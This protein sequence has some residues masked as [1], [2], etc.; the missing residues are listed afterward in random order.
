MS[1]ECV[2]AIDDI[3]KEINKKIKKLEKEKDNLEN[4]RKDFK[5][6]VCV[7]YKDSELYTY[8]DIQELYAYGI[9]TENKFE[10]LVN[11][12]ENL[13]ATS[14]TDFQIEVLEYK[15]YYYNYFKK[16]LLNTKEMEL[17][18]EKRGNS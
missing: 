12:L 2:T 1:R 3:V 6:S 8:E 11:E 5:E 4:E 17:E 9:I 15:I 16:S 13:K 10:K 7:V 18:K 14:S